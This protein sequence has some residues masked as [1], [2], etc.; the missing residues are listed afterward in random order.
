MQKI[1]EEGILEF[2]AIESHNLEL[3][4]EIYEDLKI[5]GLFCGFF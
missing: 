5:G 4:L 1:S 3:W 2:L